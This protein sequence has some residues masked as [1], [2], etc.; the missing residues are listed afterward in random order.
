[1]IYHFGKIKGIGLF[2]RPK[3]LW[4][5]LLMVFKNMMDSYTGGTNQLFSISTEGRTK[6][7]CVK[8]AKFGILSI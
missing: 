5:N 3:R 6:G 7:N 8:V 1:M 2:L 4:E